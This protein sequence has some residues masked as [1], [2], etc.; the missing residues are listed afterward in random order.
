[1]RI[2]L[3]CLLMPWLALAAPAPPST[4]NP[5]PHMVEK[6]LPLPLTVDRARSLLDATLIARNP[7]VRKAAVE[8][9]GLIGPRE[10]FRTRLMVMLEDSD[11]QVR[12]AAIASLVDLQDKTVIPAIRRAFDDPV[13]E[14]SFAAA[15]ALLAL[16]DPTGRDALMVVVT[17]NDD[18]ASG[19]LSTSGRAAMRMFYAPKSAIPYLVG[20]TIGFA[21]VAGLGAGV[22]SVEGIMSDPNV[23][24]RASA[25]LLL[26][27][28]KDPRVVPA[29]RT[30]LH[31]KDATVRAAAVHA[32]TLRDDVTL[33]FDLAS[34]IDDKDVAV[35]ARAVAGWLRLDQIEQ[36]A[37]RAGAQKAAQQ[38]TPSPPVQR[39]H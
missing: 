27:A 11:V 4:P 25:V 10:P 30:A 12:V 8:A 29:L 3:I 38:R 39:V 15:K 26:G 19:Y 6:P 22:A 9:L 1:M 7:D 23:S 34:M 20:R 2:A 36:D 35:R 31:D 33:K 5:E 17:G 21:H 18:A 16:G 37:A 32:L 28:D 14:V 13:P 24:G